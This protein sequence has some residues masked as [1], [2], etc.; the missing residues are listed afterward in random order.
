MT[1]DNVLSSACNGWSSTPH[2]EWPRYR[3][4][5][6]AWVAPSQINV[7]HNVFIRSALDISS[8]HVNDPAVWDRYLTQQFGDDLATMGDRL[9]LLLCD[10]VGMAQ[11]TMQAW[12]MDVLVARLALMPHVRIVLA[13]ATVPDANSAYNA[14]CREYRLPPVEDIK[15][16]ATYCRQVDAP[17]TDEQIQ[18]LVAVFD[19]K[20]GLF[21]EALWG[22]LMP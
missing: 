17:L 1:V 3:A 14:M 6:A 22:K 19:H 9:T 10:D 5:Q 20:P 13:G 18:V 21:A 16:Y 11:A 15:E 4:A 7:S 2:E 12:L 8:G